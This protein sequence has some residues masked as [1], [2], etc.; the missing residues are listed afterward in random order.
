MKR[1]WALIIAVSLGWSAWGFPLGWNQVDTLSYG[2]VL[3]LTANSTNSDSSAPDSA[4][5]TNNA[6]AKANIEF[7][8]LLFLTNLVCGSSIDMYGNNY[9]NNTT[10]SL[11]MTNLTFSAWFK[12][13]SASAFGDF[14]FQSGHDG[15][16]WGVYT[17]LSQLLTW[18][19]QDA[20]GASNSNITITFGH[21]YLVVATYSTTN[22]TLYCYDQTA[23]TNAVQSM[24]VGVVTGQTPGYW[25]GIYQIVNI[26]FI[27]VL[28]ELCVWNRQLTVTEIQQLY[29][30][31]YSLP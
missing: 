18:Y 20:S 23:G 2:R 9:A 21:T 25:W 6:S 14:L 8:T 12:E 30:G 7:P 31:G 16:S 15:H 4:G 5:Y 17:P 27:G 22:V 19:E 28:D 3:R 24:L 26:W 1:L 11:P 29:N 13:T 10:L